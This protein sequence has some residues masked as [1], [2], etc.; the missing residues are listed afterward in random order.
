M[1]AIEAGI[2]SLDIRQWEIAEEIWSL[3]H[4]AYRV[5]AALIGVADLPPLLDTVKDLQ[6]CKETFWGYRD[7]DGDL[8]G[9]VSYQQDKVGFY[10]ICRMMVHPNYFRQ[11]IG[12]LLMAY[13]LN[14][15]N[16]VTPTWSVTAEIRNLPAI[17]MYKRF[18]FELAETF[19]P[20][21]GIQMVSLVR[22]PC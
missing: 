20:V 7:K 4:H 19:K 9:V 17:H 22:P 16:D 15:R 8:I 18:G 10:S 5:E 14:Q 12:S 1:A 6:A 21:Q 2:V 11:G 3:Q 13:I